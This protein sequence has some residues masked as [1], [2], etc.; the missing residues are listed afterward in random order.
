MSSV[1]LFMVS[2]GKNL[3]VRKEGHYN[4]PRTDVE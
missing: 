1:A 3:I 2:K 4:A